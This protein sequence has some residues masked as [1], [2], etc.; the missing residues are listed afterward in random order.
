MWPDDNQTTNKGRM[1][2]SRQVYGKLN[3]KCSLVYQSNRYGPRMELPFC[4][5]VLL[6]YIERLQTVYPL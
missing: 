5:R 2:R 6:S 4:S 3:A 1:E